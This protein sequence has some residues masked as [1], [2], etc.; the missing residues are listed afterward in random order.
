MRLYRVGEYGGLI[1][2]PVAP[3]ASAAAAGT[4]AT[5][6]TLDDAGDYAQVQPHA[7]KIPWAYAHGTV[8]VGPG[9]WVAVAVNGRVAA[10]G[11]TSTKRASGQA[12]LATLLP[13]QLMKTGANDVRLYVVSGPANAPRLAPTALQHKE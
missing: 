4:P 3:L 7:R 12:T 10:V 1:G 5:P 6:A 2:S 13:P 11:M 8:D 9:Q